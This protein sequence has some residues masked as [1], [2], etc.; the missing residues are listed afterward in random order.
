MVISRDAYL[1]VVAAVGTERI[2]E[3]ILSSYNAR[4]TLRQ[5][6]IE[7]GRGLYR[8]MA[9]FHALFLLSAVCEA[10]LFRPAVGLAVS[11]V[12]FGAT[13]GAQAL[14]YWAVI[15][16]GARWNTRIIVIP[17]A[18]SVVS[19]PYRFVRHPNY[20]AV[21]IEMVSVP[22][23][24]GCWRTAAIFSCGNAILLALRIAHE[25]RALGGKYVEAF[26]RVPRLVP[27][28]VLHLFDGTM[29]K[30]CVKRGDSE[31]GRK[32][33]KSRHRHVGG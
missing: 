26:A 5:G 1:A 31:A 19:G 6:A 14:R 25:E 17:G 20:L 4:R 3:L 32:H 33:W 7:S 8:V 24:Y 22:M 13:I 10:F 29:A 11:L 16:L 21:I 27:L 12:A 30:P 9:G 18:A 28:A 23:M 15:T 2:F